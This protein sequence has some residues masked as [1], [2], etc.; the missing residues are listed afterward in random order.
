MLAHCDPRFRPGLSVFLEGAQG[1][2]GNHRLLIDTQDALEH[3]SRIE[4]IVADLDKRW[5]FCIRSEKPFILVF[6]P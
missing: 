4:R 1:L 2:S 3:I 6:T 5:R